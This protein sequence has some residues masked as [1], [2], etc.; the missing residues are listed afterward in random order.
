MFGIQIGDTG[1]PIISRRLTLLKFGFVSCIP[2][3]TTTH[4]C[5]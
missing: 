4:C 1:P 2:Q 5:S 3:L